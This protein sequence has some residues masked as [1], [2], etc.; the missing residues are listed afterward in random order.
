[1]LLFESQDLDLVL[2]QSTLGPQLVGKFYRTLKVPAAGKAPR[3]SPLQ[4][5]FPAGEAGR[6][7]MTW[8][9][10]EVG[11]KLAHIPPQH[12]ALFGTRFV[13]GGG[14]ADFRLLVDTPAL[15][16]SLVKWLALKAELAL[17]DAPPGGGGGD[18]Q[19]RHFSDVEIADIKALFGQMEDD[20]AADLAQEL[21]D[22]YCPQPPAAG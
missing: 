11:A 8:L 9:K 7:L 12:H 5:A 19:K 20:Q 13:A 21:H 6:A 1:M 10:R 16:G 17:P 22:Q 4:L 15:N 14:N 2:R 3:E 18:G